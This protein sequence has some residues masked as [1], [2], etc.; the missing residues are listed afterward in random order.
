M[1]RVAVCD[2]LIENAIIIKDFTDIYLKKHCINYDITVYESGKNLLYDLNDG[3]YFD[4]LLLDIEMPD[5]TGM[6]LAKFIKEKYPSSRI[7]FIT[8][9]SEYAIDAYEFSIFRYI[10][11]NKLESKLIGALDDFYKMYKLEKNE[12]YTIQ[13]KNNILKIPYKDILYILKDGK[14]AILYLQNGDQKKVRKTLL[15]LYDEINDNYFY[16]ADRGCIVNLANVI[17][18]NVTSVLFPKNHQITISKS[19]ILEFKQKMLEFWGNHI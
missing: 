17:G 5:V 4:L 18:L 15:Q 9:H 8:S 12:F 6:D 13:V 19:S 16:F 1:L 11:K 10:Q 7:I 14:Y 3:L 2:D